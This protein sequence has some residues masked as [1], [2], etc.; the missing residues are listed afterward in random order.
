MELRHLRYF[1]AVAEE[2]HFG[3]AAETLH[4]AQPPLSQQIRQLEAELD[5]RLF[6]RTTRRVD[7]TEAGRLLVERA[8][9]ILADVDSTVTD[10]AEVGRG[11]AGVLRIG[12]SGTATYRLMPEIVRLARHRLPNVRLQV[13]GEML[14]PQMETGL[15][16]NRIDAAVLRPPIASPDIRL[17]EFEQTQLVVALPTDHPLAHER[18]PLAASALSGEDLVSYPRGS[19]VASVAAEISRQAGF[20]PRIVQE[21]TETST[22][23]AL[24]AA[25]LGLCVLPASSAL[26]LSTATAIRPLD[27]AVTIG[28]ATGWRADDASPLVAA[29]IDLVRDAAAALR[30]EARRPTDHRPTL[31][32][33]EPL[34]AP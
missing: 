17:D 18:G 5:T 31:S 20:R 21:A 7:L 34:E 15:L 26:P 24:V 10:V 23:I 13:V 12:F 28:L 8:T 19:A 22:L 1:L 25:G 27:P 16:E 29:F 33:P 14:T 2:R 32:D 4:M 30:P 3:R 9:Q 11:A 6:E